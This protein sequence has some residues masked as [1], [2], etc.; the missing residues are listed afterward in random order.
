MEETRNGTDIVAL[1]A[2][3]ERSME[4]A[5]GRPDEVLDDC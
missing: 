3:P 5:A 2:A 1:A 4:R